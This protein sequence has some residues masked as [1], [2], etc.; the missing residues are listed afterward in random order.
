MNLQDYEHHM[1]GRRYR[2]KQ[3]TTPTKQH[4]TDWTFALI[5]F[6]IGMI[7]GIAILGTFVLLMPMP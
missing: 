1:R 2:D 5:F 7:A 6:T 4:D 3:M